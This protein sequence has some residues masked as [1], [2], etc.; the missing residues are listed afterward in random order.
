MNTK[1]SA[2]SGGGGAS[3]GEGP[4]VRPEPKPHPEGSG[5]DRTAA[6]LLA[7][8]GAPE[9]YA[10]PDPLAEDGLILRTERGG[11]SV[12]G[13]RFPRAAGAALARA[14]LA[15]RDPRGALRIS[16]AGRAHLRRRRTD[17][18][19]AP[20]RAQHLALVSDRLPD[21]DGVPMPVRRD[22]AESPLE[23]MRRRRGRN[24]T[25]LL[26][27]ASFEAG[28][29]LRRDLTFAALLPRTTVNWSNAGANAQG[30]MPRDPAAASDAVIAARQ[31]VTHALEAVGSD[32]SGLLVD[33]CGFLKGLER[34]ERDRDWP[35]RSGKVAAR[36][37]LGRLAEHY[38]LAREAQGPARALG[39]RA[40]RE[41]G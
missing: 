9:A 34:I 14:D 8:L 36:L 6:R 40:W 25:P 26:D 20:F 38:G 15:T 24:G 3:R 27:A 33:L 17:A 5:L 23:W 39:I 28:E 29:R 11:V 10:F 13:G 37:A 4:A 19:D 12:G 16:S 31:R 7:A 41:G 18:D 30:P 2:R 32:L 22:A 35:P 1:R 21:A